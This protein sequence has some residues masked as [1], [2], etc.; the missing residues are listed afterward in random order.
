MYICNRWRYISLSRLTYHPLP[1]F[2]CLSISI[3]T[4]LCSLLSTNRLSNT[5][6]SVLVWN[7]KHTILNTF[8]VYIYQN[9]TIIEHRIRWPYDLNTNTSGRYILVEH[10]DYED[11]LLKNNGSNG[12][13]FKERRYITYL[14][15]ATQS[16]GR[17]KNN[18]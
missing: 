5:H 16:T 6:L 17:E 1:I 12:D 11:S 2:T 14:L 8:Q 4:N 18:C 15:I 13:D 9:G 3:L 7:K 10:I